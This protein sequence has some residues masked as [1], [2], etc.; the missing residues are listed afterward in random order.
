MVLLAAAL[1]SLASAARAQ[2]NEPVPLSTSPVVAASTAAAVLVSSRPVIEG[3]RIERLNVFDL[4]LPGEDYWP[5]RFANKI[6]VVTRQKV[7]RRELLLHPGDPWDPLL[8]LESER[9]MRELNI[10]RYA[11][12]RPVPRPDGKID[13]DVKT[14]DAWTTIPIFGIGTEGGQNS[15]SYGFEE[16]NVLGMGKQIAA[17]HS[18]DG[19][20]LRDE[21]RYTD[22]R[23]LQTR[24]ALSPYYAKTNLG[25]AIGTSLDLPF[26]TLTDPFAGQVGWDRSIDQVILYQNGSQST[27][28]VEQNRVVTAGYA[29]RL[30]H[31]ENFVQ[32]GEVGWYAQKAAF[33]AT[34]ETTPGTLPAGREMSGPTAGYYWIAP[35]YVKENY[36]NKMEHVEDFDLGNEL[37]LYGGYMAK[38][39]ASDEDRWLF[40]V[41]DQQ[42]FYFMPGRFALGQVGANGRVAGTQL[43][44]ALFFANMNLFWKMDLGL[45][46]T[47]VAHMEAN[48]GRNLDLENQV[49]LG[50]NNGLRG[51][52]SYSFVGDKSMLFNVEDRVFFPG[53]YFHLARF[54]VAAFYDVGEVAPQGSGITYDGFK[55]DAGVGLRAAAT[56]SQSGGVVRLDVAYALNQG[57]GGSRW[58]VSLAGG[59]GFDMFNS[60]AR[61]VRESPTTQLEPAPQ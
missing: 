13:L 11:D 14:Q 42:G 2:I 25:D 48:Q 37:T 10:F 17:Y 26:L 58:V 54:G 20:I 1:L 52:K 30:N 3:I 50:G 46:Q 31:G 43:E 9:N 12:V 55:A 4:S 16:N 57:P 51:Y 53:E 59:Q 44:N 27:S 45:P 22:P 38:A 35:R 7:V 6:H 23:F 15:F 28:F 24:M 39:L 19:P 49:V 36:I 18:Q 32:R 60:S 5:F 61:D 8:A 41:M 29:T 40:N 47:L 56:R 34:S 21:V 33:M